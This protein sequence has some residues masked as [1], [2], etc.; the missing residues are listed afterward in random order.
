[1]KRF[2]VGQ[3]QT[4]TLTGR[5]SKAAAFYELVIERHHR[6]ATVVSERSHL[7]GVALDTQRVAGDHHLG[8]TR[9]A[10]V[11]QCSWRHAGLI[12]LANDTSHTF[13]VTAKHNRAFRTPMTVD[14]PFV[15]RAGRGES[16]QLRSSPRACGPPW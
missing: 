4:G 1:M 12:V 6:A 16:E 10:E 2:L 15:H 8:P 5:E 11:V 7:D 9:W 14:L 13:E 3:R